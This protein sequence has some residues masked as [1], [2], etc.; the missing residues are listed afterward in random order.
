M[1]KNITREYD[2]TGRALELSAN[3]AVF[4]PGLASVNDPKLALEAK[5]L[6]IY[7]ADTNIYKLSAVKQFEKYIGDVDL[8]EEVILPETAT[9][10]KVNPS[11]ETETEAD[12]IFHIDAWEAASFDET[13]YNYY[14][15]E[16]E[17]TTQPSTWSTTRRLWI[18][19]QAE[20]SGE[21]SELVTKY[22]KLVKFTKSEMQEFVEEGG[23]IS[24]V[25]LLKIK[26]GN[27]GLNVSEG[28][29]HLGN[30]IA[31]ELLEIGY[32]VY[33]K[34]LENNDKDDPD[35]NKT[36][37]AQLLN[38]DLWEPL[39]DRSTYRIRYL[40][41]GGCYNYN[42]YKLMA[43][44]ANF[45]NNETLTKAYTLE[46]A[47]GRGDCVALLDID[48]TNLVNLNTQ[49]AIATA[50]GDEAK[51]IG[52]QISGAEKYCAIFAPRVVYTGSEDYDIKYPASFNYLLCAAKARENYAEWW[53][54]AGYTRGISYKNIEYTTYNFG[55]LLINTLAPRQGNGYTNI[56]INL[57]LNERGNYYLWGN[58]TALPLDMEKDN[59]KFSHFLNVRQLC[60]TLK[61][62][63]YEATRQ[64]T[65]DPNSDI[66]WINF[67]NAIRPT[68]ERMK[69]D[70]GIAGYK[71][72]KV[73]TDKKA[74]MMAK[75][76]IVPIEAVEDFDISIYLEDSIDGIVVSADETEAE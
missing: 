63:I 61:Q 72:S 26:V 59:L 46:A 23:D 20:S 6:G 36:V 1:P 42:V 56:A 52:S 54:A 24:S 13:K 51:L 37:L 22:Y 35:P 16:S 31:R 57:I 12:Y 66:L 27:E 60:I 28:E 19:L 48:E 4:V 71:I 7:Y 55:D 30:K 43:D 38:R 10:E 73:A 34:V 21:G 39:K 50:F 40:T 58:R 5:K 69:G 70:Q 8:D 68:L 45:N 49:E 9:P 74:V 2:N 53:A 11:S 25:A 65:F 75:I 62:T 67:V 64:F 29:R 33:Y 15:V 3:F 32:T 76:R 47:S 14:E 17:T 44:V 41:N 18:V